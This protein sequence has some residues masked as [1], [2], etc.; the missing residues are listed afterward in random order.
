MR[1]WL[2]KDSDTDFALR[3]SPEC[4][5]ALQTA[6][7]EHVDSA[8]LQLRFFPTFDPCPPEGRMN[9]ICSSQCQ[10]DYIHVLQILQLLLP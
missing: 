10:A 3:N 4:P 7:D 9:Y 2:P 5:A 8:W 1:Q 6:L